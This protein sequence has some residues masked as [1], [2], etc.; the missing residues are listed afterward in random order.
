[1][2]KKGTKE[3][4]AKGTAKAII[5][6]AMKQHP[7]WNAKKISE[8]Y[9]VGESTCHKYMKEIRGALPTVEEQSNNR[10]LVFAGIVAGIALMLLFIIAERGVQ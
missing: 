5:A 2:A 6:N 8:N 10:W 1:M 3:R 7:T 9:P 4:C